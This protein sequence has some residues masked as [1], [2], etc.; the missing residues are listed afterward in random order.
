[1]TA[2]EYAI[3]WGLGLEVEQVP[4]NPYT[5]KY[6]DGYH[7]KVTFRRPGTTHSFYMYFSK[8][9][10][11][12]PTVSE[13]LLELAMDIYT[14]RYTDTFADWCEELGY[15]KDSPKAEK[16]YLL[17]QHQTLI[18][19]DFLPTTAYNQLLKIEG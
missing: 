15:D 6:T 17:I 12:K 13:I 7:Y 1:M 2:I 9:S 8:L 11:D 14:M 3:Q 18:L 5:L 10:E 4:E 19:R 16:L